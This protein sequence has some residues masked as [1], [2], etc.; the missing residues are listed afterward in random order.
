MSAAV[1][2]E[3]APT[4]IPGSPL[5]GP[6]PVGEYAE[7]L[8]AKLRSFAQVQ[9][10]GELVNTTVE[11]TGRPLGQLALVIVGVVLAQAGFTFVAQRTST[12]FGQD[13]LSTAREFIVRTILRL[14]LGAVESASTGDLVTLDVP[15]RRLDVDVSDDELARRAGEWTAPETT[16]GSGYRW[17]YRQHV[18]QAEDGADFD[19]LTGSRG[20]AVPRD[21]H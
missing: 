17:L 20:S 3:P 1:P 11:G 2:N 5:A 15:A 6:F 9:L 18:Q 4:G 21:S 14:P 7:A 10:L 8:R 19:F 16:D 13:L 12:L